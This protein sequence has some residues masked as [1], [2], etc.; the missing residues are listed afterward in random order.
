[1]CANG[2]INSLM[3]EYAQFLDK[4]S[5]IYNFKVTD[6]IV[7][8]VLNKM[9]K[10]WFNFLENMSI[11]EFN[12]VFIDGI[13]G[14]ED[15]V[16]EGMFVDIPEEIQRFI[17][18]RRELE[19][20]CPVK[21][22][23]VSQSSSLTWC[24]RRG[25]KKKKEHE[26]VN[27]AC[28][29]EEKCSMVGVGD[30]LDVGC[31]LGYLG[32]ELTRRGLTVLGIEGHQGHARRAN[33]RR[34]KRGGGNFCTEVVQ[35]DSSSGPALESLMAPLS[36]SALVGLHCC[37]SLSPCLL[38]LFPRLETAQALVLVSCCYHRME[39]QDFPLS[40]ALRATY[41]PT[42][43]VYMLRLGAQ[44][45]LCTW[46]RQGPQDHLRHMLEVGGRA[47]LELAATQA[48][49]KLGRKKGNC[50]VPDTEIEEPQD[51]TEYIHKGGESDEREVK[52]EMESPE[53]S[54]L[55]KDVRSKWG[56][57]SNEVKRMTHLLRPAYT[58]WRQTFPVMELL[59]GLQFLLQGPIEELVAMDRAVYL[60][61]QGITTP[62]ELLGIFNPAISPRNI[63]ICATKL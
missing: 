12:K 1:M 55:L 3:T 15:N 21:P 25:V 8:D 63:A 42:A 62:V 9:P 57:S 47:V 44:E 58:A 56:L 38:S 37:G 18:E 13:S 39:E 53:L 17:E 40:E 2:A 41:N 49:L 32:E 36:G 23:P 27:F 14:D 43:K 20:K 11:D 24:Q 28:L 26:I 59:T 33:I 4:Y 19:R 60:E 7:E 30:V 22:R 51:E 48:G 46:A 31:G 5:W 52:Q 45:R 34:E 6:W 54:S 29:I 10:V 61:E 50:A 35:V 16:S